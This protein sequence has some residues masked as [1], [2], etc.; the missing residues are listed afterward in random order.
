MS[1]FKFNDFDTKDRKYTCIKNNKVDSISI[2]NNMIVILSGNH[3]YLICECKNPEELNKI[4]YILTEYYLK[5][6]TDYTYEINDILNNNI[7]DHLKIFS[8]YYIDINKN[9]FKISE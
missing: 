5:D 3:E 6:D 7:I 9:I 8:K 4:Y 2:F 1:W